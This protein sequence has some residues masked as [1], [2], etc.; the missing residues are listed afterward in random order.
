MNTEGFIVPEQKKNQS[1]YLILS[2]LLVFSGSGLISI[3]LLNTNYGLVDV[4]LIKIPNEN[5]YLTG[6]LYKPIDASGDNPLPTVVCAHGFSN[7]KH[8]MSGMALELGR[9]GFIALALDLAGH[10]NSEP[11]KDDSSLGIISAIEYLDT[12]PYADSN[13]IGIVG[14]SM[15]AWAAWA[16]ALKHGNI[17]ATVLIGGL[18]DLSVNGTNSGKYNSTFP[19]NLLVAVGE[20]DEF[21][22]DVNL[23]TTDLMEIFGTTN[24]VVPNDAFYGSFQPERQ[25]ARRLVISST[26]HILEPIDPLIVTETIQWMQTALK[27][28]GYVDEY[29]IPHSNLIFP[30]RDVTS[31]I[32][33]ISIICLFLSI[34]SLIYH[35]NAFEEEKSSH[36]LDFEKPSLKKTGLVWGSL[37]IVLYFPV[38][39]I[40]T[41]IPVPPMTFAPSIALWFLMINSILFAIIYLF[42]SYFEMNH[43]LREVLKKDRRVWWVKRGVGLVC[44][45]IAS[46]YGIMFILDN[47]FSIQLGF[48]IA[49]FS[50]LLIFPR[51]VSFVILLPLFLIYF[52][53]DGL[54]FHADLT[55]SKNESAFRDDL[56]QMGRLLVAKVWPFFLVVGCIYIPRIIFGINLLPGGLITLSIQ[57]YWVLGLFII[58]GSLISWF[59]YR[60]SNS[61][62]PG[63]VFNSLLFVWILTSLLPV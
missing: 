44:G 31:L 6:L 40:G 63:A 38:M 41:F 50:N 48:I 14:H 46:L 60:L 57:F 53:I 30:L 33:L 3:F 2:I 4:S 17:S 16:T 58:A 51:I 32:T 24:P 59:W 54:F 45:I 23:L 56:I 35:T 9:R 15:G 47:F 42:S 37:V 13:S 26:I 27:V 11:S 1:S 8:T 36:K 18:P 10:G 49:F 34:A 61:I 25:D 21:F 7:S 19:K 62:V 43:S 39:L 5:S 28:D 55:A 29:F 12:L 52:L 20:Y 22:T